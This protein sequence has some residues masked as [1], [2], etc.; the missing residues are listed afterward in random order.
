MRIIYK[1]G[2]VLEC[3]KIDVIQHGHVH[4]SDC[5]VCDGTKFVKVSEV[6]HVEFEP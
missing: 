4:E 2:D 3:K 1:N 5:Y 6:D